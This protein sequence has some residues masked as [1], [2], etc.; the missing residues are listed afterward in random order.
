MGVWETCCLKPLDPHTWRSHHRHGSESRAAAGRHSPEGQ[1]GDRDQGCSGDPQCVGAAGG[2]SAMEEVGGLRGEG[3]SAVC[4]PQ[5]D[6]S[7]FRV[8]AG[9][10]WGAMER[11]QAQWRGH[12]GTLQ[13]L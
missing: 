8:A 12:L 13:P 4:S 7:T 3:V 11:A 5:R 1:C 6:A 10:E 9:V 2:H